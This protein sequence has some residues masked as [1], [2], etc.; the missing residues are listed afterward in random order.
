MFLVLK[1]QGFSKY[2]INKFNE[3][4][5][6]TILSTTVKIPMGLHMHF[7][8]IFMEELAKVCIRNT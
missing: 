8:E 5:S 3:V 7:I 4:L 1:E 6:V 2:N